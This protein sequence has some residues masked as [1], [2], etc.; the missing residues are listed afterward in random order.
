MWSWSVK[1]GNHKVSRYTSPEYRLTTA[2]G[3][4]K[5]EGLGRPEVPENPVPLERIDVA[6]AESRKIVGCSPGASD[7]FSVPV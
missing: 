6:P 5:I 4:R 7:R 3:K 1:P 2:E